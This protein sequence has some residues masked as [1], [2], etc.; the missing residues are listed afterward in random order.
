MR[1][2][3]MISPTWGCAQPVTIKLCR[4]YPRDHELAGETPD[5]NCFLLVSSGKE[6]LGE[7]LVFEEDDP[8]WVKDMMKDWDK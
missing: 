6:E 2:G 7:R 5:P 3:A 4:A 1:Y 8:P